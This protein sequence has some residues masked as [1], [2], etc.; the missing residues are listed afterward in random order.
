MSEK[1]TVEDL[2][3]KL[4]EMHGAYW[5][6]IDN[7]A[8]NIL[9]NRQGDPIVR[10]ERLA[11]IMMEIPS[12]HD[13]NIRNGLSEQ[14]KTYLATE[15]AMNQIAFSQFAKK[16]SPENAGRIDYLLSK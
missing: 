13:Y 8:R 16:F 3:P 1:E 12:D 15:T 5:D 14:V 7:E 10:I 11:F 6:R 2:S 4:G 9:E